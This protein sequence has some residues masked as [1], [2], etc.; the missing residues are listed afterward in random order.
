MKYLLVLVLFFYS[1]S[2][3]QF[4]PSYLKPRENP[5]LEKKLSK[6]LSENSYCV[7]Y[8]N[9]LVAHSK[10]KKIKELDKHLC[11]KNKNY[12]H[13]YSSYDEIVA[14]GYDN[15]MKTYKNE[16][17]KGDDRA[18]STV[19]TFKFSKKKIET[20]IIEKMGRHAVDSNLLFIDDFNV[21]IN[22][23][24]GE[25]G[26]GF[27]YILDSLNPER[28]LVAAEAIGI[29]ENALDRA[30]SYAKERKVFNIPIGK[31][32]SIQHPLATGWAQLEAAKLMMFK[33]ANLYDSNLSC[34]LEANAAKY[35]AAEVGME[36]CKHAVATHGGMGYA[37]E[38]H[39][40]RLFREM[41]IPYLAPVSQQ[42]ILCYIAERALGLAK[43][44]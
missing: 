3:T 10:D 14:E 29:A 43:S 7:A 31:N 13:T 21:P 19:E 28:I 36:I 40:E 16:C 35:L 42:L 6:C 41:M 37:K 23:L 30:V 34:G 11:R 4:D 27:K 39:V 26:K 12:C 22:H 24:I 44:Y 33:A 17:L 20:K 1:C 15:V 9:Y 18:C 2:T 38:Y 32:Q 25:E 5:A 8:R